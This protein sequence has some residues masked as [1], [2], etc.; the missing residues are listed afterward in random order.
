M[1]VSWVWWASLNQQLVQDRGIPLWPLGWKSFLLYW[2]V[3]RCW[4]GLLVG[5]LHHTSF[6]RA[7]AADPV[8]RQV[9]DA[10]SASMPSKRMMASKSVPSCWHNPTWWQVH[11]IFPPPFWTSMYNIFS[12]FVGGAGH[13]LLQCILPQSH[14]QWEK[15]WLSVTHVST[16]QALFHSG[17]NCVSSVFLPIVPV[18]W[19]PLA[20]AHTFLGGFAVDIP[21]GCCNVT[22][23]VACNGVVWHVREF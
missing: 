2:G 10:E 4:S 23:V 14:L 19:S 7:D 11:N 6:W 15:K 21:I 20:G 3:G 16:S 1:G 5:L 18:Q 12:P 22:Q 9:G 8:V 17:C 13:V